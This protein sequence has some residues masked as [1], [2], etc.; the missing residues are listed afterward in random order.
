MAA[1][2]SGQACGWA[3]LA[4]AVAAATMAGGCHTPHQCP[5]LQ[6]ATG[7]NIP[8]PLPP[9]GASY[10]VVGYRDGIRFYVVRYNDKLYRGGDIRSAEGARALEDLGIQTVVSIT[11]NDKERRLAEEHGFQLVEIPFGWYSMNASHLDRF[12]EAMDAAEGPVYVHSKF[13]INRAGILAAHYRAHREG[14]S[15]EKALDEYWRLDANRF[16]TVHLVKV[17]KANAPG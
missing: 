10:D 8:S 1:T 15:V 7:G 2:P 3:V 12:L 17:L 6:G 16:D 4:A 5:W 11:P 9:E 14:W 13:G